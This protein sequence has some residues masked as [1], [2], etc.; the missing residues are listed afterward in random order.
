MN[1]FTNKSNVTIKTSKRE[2]NNKNRK[3]K[4]DDKQ[5]SIKSEID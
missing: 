3:L 2:K 5:F 1:Y 4:K